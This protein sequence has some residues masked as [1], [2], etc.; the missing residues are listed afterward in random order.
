MKTIL[1]AFIIL[2]IFDADILQAQ[3]L[4]KVWETTGLKNGSNFMILGKFS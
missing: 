4:E 2:L 1:F 3:K